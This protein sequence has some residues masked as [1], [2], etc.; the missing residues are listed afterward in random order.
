MHFPSQFSIFYKTLKVSANIDRAVIIIALNFPRVLL[1]NI[2]SFLTTV[3]EMHCEGA[4]FL[5]VSIE[6]LTFPVL[7]EFKANKWITVLFCVR[8]TISWKII[9]L[10]TMYRSWIMCT[11][12]GILPIKIS[13]RLRLDPW[14]C[15]NFLSTTKVIESSRKFLKAAIVPVTLLQLVTQFYV[16]MQIRTSKQIGVCNSSS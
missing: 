14:E 11:W 7:P 1:H 6:F 5:S 4:V 9:L 15:S 8:N 3:F 16:S 10:H 12:F 2:L 13:N